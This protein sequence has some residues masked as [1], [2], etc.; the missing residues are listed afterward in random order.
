MTRLRRIVVFA[1]V[2]VG[3]AT[4]YFLCAMALLRVGVR[5][6]ALTSLIAYAISGV[7]SYLG[8]RL[9]TFQ[10]SA[11]HGR[12]LP[13]F[14]LANATGYLIAVLVPLLL[15]DVMNWPP[16]IATVLV[17]VAV[18]ATN[19]ILLTMFVFWKPANVRF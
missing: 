10:S 7:F 15:T 16:L 13:R 19:F 5:P 11:P 9:F 12:T 14:V 4:V 3:A 18:P 2:G 1:A 8:H 6:A 17:C